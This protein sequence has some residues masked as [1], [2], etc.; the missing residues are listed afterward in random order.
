MENN[1]NNDFLFSSTFKAG[2]RT[3]FFD[4]KKTRGEELY[5]TITESKKFTNIDTGEVKFEKH[6]VFLYKEDFEK[7]M[8]SLTNSFDY[9]KKESE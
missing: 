8:E 1:Q 2:R 4:V 7:F 6:R 5:L 3:Y 9:I